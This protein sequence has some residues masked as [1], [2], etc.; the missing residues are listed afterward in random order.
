MTAPSYQ[1]LDPQTLDDPYPVFRAMREQGRPVWNEALDSWVLTSYAH[2]RAV[3]SDPVRFAADFRRAG[4]TVAD[5]GLDVHTIDPPEHTAI[6]SVL[7]SVIN[8]MVTPELSIDVR[9]KVEAMVDDLPAGPVN[10]IEEFTEPLARWF[11]PRAIGLPPFDLD[12]VAP[13]ADAITA[14]MDSGLNPAAREPGIAAQ[15]ALAALIEEWVADLPTDQHLP[16]LV[17]KASDAGVPRHIIMNS[18]RTL[19]VNGF[20]AIPASL[21]NALHAVGQHR[22][23]LAECTRPGDLSRT[24]HEFFRYEAAIQG[25]TRLAV[26]DTDLFGAPV[27]RGQGVLMLFA[28]ANRDPDV[29]ANPDGITPDRWPNPHLAFGYGAHACTGSV[30]A[31]LLLREV[32]SVLADR[33][34]MVCLDRP[35]VHKR[36]ATVRTLDTLRAELKE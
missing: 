18:M 24:A 11:I 7:A 2:C 20:T 26:T 35:G 27:K 36:L 28:A 1:P 13:I 9:S 33:K 15:G 3:L 23:R 32:L 8:K 25:T 17:R 21:G 30:L 19:V 6:Y 14:A 16:M 34:L 12:V 31:A 5:V 22:I 4:E 10:L 29:F